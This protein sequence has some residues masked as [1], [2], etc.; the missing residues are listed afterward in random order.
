MIGRKTHVNPNAPSG[1]RSTRAR[2]SVKSV[3]TWSTM[4]CDQVQ[5]PPPGCFS[6]EELSWYGEK[7]PEAWFEANRLPDFIRGEEERDKFNCVFSIR[8][9]KKYQDFKGGRVFKS[10]T[11]YHC[12]YGPQDY[13]GDAISTIPEDRKSST[14]KF[15]LK[16]KRCTGVLSLAMTYFPTLHHTA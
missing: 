14:G 4:P 13:R 2:T 3:R 15:F 11:T 16:L 6:Q 5:Y 1:N 8:K 9:S 7:N 12:C 10:S